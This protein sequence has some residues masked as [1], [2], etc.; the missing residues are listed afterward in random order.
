[1]KKRPELTGGIK[2]A[3]VTRDNLGRPEIS[4]TMDSASAE[5][6]GQIRLG[7]WVVSSP[8]CWTAS[9]RRRR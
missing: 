2:S 8:S 3:M 4:F 1:V 7:T 9:C 5:T 6:F